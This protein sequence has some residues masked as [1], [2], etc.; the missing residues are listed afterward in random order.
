MEKTRQP[1]KQRKRMNNV[2]SRKGIRVHLSKDLRKKY[3]LRTFGLR[4]GDEVKIVRGKFK[5]KISKV[6]KTVPKK[7]RVYI[8][9]IQIQKADGTKAK[10]SIHPSNLII[11][12]LD[13][14][15]KLRKEKIEKFIKKVK[16]NE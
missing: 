11:T 4:K 9:G 7:A 1:R 12:G 5:G 15:D 14:S 13:L 3:S 16:R 2:L 8:E 6:E 10:V